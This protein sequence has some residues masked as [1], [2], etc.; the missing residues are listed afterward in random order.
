[1]RYQQTSLSR[2][3]GIAM[4]A[5]VCAIAFSFSIVSL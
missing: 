4:F 5:T 1:M 2:L 3:L